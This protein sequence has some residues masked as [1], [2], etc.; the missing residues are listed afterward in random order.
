MALRCLIVDDNRAFLTAATRL[1]ER[2]GVDVVGVAATG[3]EAIDLARVVAPDVVLIDIYL[4]PENGLDLVERLQEAGGPAASV[5]LISTRSA[6][7]VLESFGSRP[8]LPFVAK[9]DLSAE[10]ISLAANRTPENG[11]PPERGG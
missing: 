8:P 4:G 6:D 10:T 5:V 11:A 3:G 9:A 1:L 2:E 7:D